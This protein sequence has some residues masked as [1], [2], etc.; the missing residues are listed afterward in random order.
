MDC[1]PSRFQRFIPESKG[2][3]RLQVDPYDEEKI[4]SDDTIIRRISP[5]QHIIWDENRQKK[6]IASKA[7]NKSSGL[8]AGMSVDVENLVVAAGQDPKTYVTTP[9]FTG[10]V[11]FSAG[12]VRALELW[13][14]YEPIR[15][16]PGAPDNPHHGEVWA[17]TAKVA[18]SNSQKTGIAKQARWYVELPDVDII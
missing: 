2:L 15:N 9:I 5:A 4:G 17:K 14:G 3:A 16:M 11:S 6:R 18:F 10:S 8:T 13:V 7:F 1:R 12:V